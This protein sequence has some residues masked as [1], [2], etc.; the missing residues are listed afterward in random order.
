MAVALHTW[1][2]AQGNGLGRTVQNAYALSGIW[3]DMPTP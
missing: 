3:I 1:M 2:L